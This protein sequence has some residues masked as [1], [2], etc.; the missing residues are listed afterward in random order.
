[1]LTEIHYPFTMHQAMAVIWTLAGLRLNEILRLTVG[2]VRKQTE[3]IVQDVGSIIPA[4]M[5]CW[6]DVPAGK[7]SKAFVNARRQCRE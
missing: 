5:L 4:G 1:M 6:L 7:T 3:D 2:C